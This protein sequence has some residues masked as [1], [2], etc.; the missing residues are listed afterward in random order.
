L[1]PSRPYRLLLEV[2]IVHPSF[3]LHFGRIDKFN[4]LH[5]VVARKALM[6][7]LPFDDDVSSL[8]RSDL[9]AICRV[10]I[11]ANARANL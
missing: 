7:V 2:G 6:T 9:A 11:E 10:T 5:F 3:T 4:P 8:N 1:R